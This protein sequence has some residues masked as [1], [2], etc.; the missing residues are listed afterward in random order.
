MGPPNE[1]YNR[2]TQGHQGPIINYP[3]DKYGQDTHFLGHQQ[4]QTD[5]PTPMEAK[6][7]EH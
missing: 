3:K 6:L 5:W 4:N 2:G 1:K 7:L